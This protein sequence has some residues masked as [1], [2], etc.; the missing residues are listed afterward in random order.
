MLVKLLAMGSFVRCRGTPQ[1]EARERHAGQAEAEFLQRLPS[2]DG[3]GHAF[4]QFIE[5]VVHNSLSL[6]WR[7]M[8]P[9]WPQPTFYLCSAPFSDEND[10]A[11]RDLYAA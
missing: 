11:R 7:V 4:G 5:L 9:P 10:Q 1:P 6:Y 3:L 8:R 2:G